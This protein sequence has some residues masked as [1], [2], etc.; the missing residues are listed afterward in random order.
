MDWDCKERA[1]DAWNKIEK[2][3]LRPDRGSYTIMIRWLCDKGRINDALHCFGE[4]TSKGIVS[5]SR[6][7]M[8]ASA[9]NMRSMLSKEK[10]AI[11]GEKL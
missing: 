8:L 1:W 2:Y 6:T 9:V 3:G 7:E 4:M 11:N 5:E 10:R